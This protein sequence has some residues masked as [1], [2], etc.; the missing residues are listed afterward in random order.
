MA[1][2]HNRPAR[3]TR[4]RPPCAPLHLRLFQSESSRWNGP[5]RRSFP[6]LLQ[7]RPASQIRRSGARE[8]DQSLAA[9][10]VNNFQCP[11][12]TTSTVPPDTLIAVSSSIA[13]VETGTLAAH[14]SMFAMELSS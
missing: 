6:I 1:P 2:P 14:L 13:Y 7:C 11:S 9:V 5:A 10:G 12:E 8:A 4:R 3:A